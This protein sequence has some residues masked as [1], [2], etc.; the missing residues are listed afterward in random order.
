MENLALIAPI[1]TTLYT[2]TGSSS[3]AYVGGT[4]YPPK[5]LNVSVAT[6]ATITLPP[7]ALSYPTTGN[8]LGVGRGAE[9][10]INNLAAV[11]VTPAAA[12]SD[13]IIGGSGTIAN[14][15]S[16]LLISDPDNTR[17]VRVDN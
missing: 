15:G 9:I 12:G 16:A 7:I 10:R 8:G 3:L 11:A 6:A 14:G 1:R 2:T 4:A 13:T 5:V 17:W